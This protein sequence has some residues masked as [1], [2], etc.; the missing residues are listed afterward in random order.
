MV[1]IR[2]LWGGVVSYWNAALAVL[3][4]TASD[5]STFINRLAESWRL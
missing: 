1:L 5:Y 2:Y 3:E 4:Q